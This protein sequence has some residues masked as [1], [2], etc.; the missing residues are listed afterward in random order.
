MTAT[1]SKTYEYQA[2]D[3]KGNRAKGR[4]EALNQ[5][6][7][8]QILRQRGDMPLVVEEAGKGLRRDI[9]VPGFGPKVTLKDLTVLSRQ[10]ATLVSSGM[11]LLRALGVLAEQTSNA[12][13]KEAVTEVRSDVEAGIG[14]SDALGRQSE[15]F[16][17]LMVALVRAGEAGG[18]IDQA[19]EQ[20]AV[21][22]EK[23]SALRSKIKS[24]LTY[25]AI[26][27]AFSVIL[28]AAVLIFIVPIFEDMFAQLGGELPLVT[29]L[30]VSA[31]HAIAWVG[32]VLLALSVGGVLLFQRELK[33]NPAT[34]LA[35]DRFK[36]RLPVFGPLLRKLAM[37]R[38]SRNLGTLLNV[39]VP[40]LNALSVVGATT[41]NA[42][43]TEAMK[44]L[45]DAVREGRPM[46]AQMAEQELFPAMVTQMVEVG[47][48]TGE[49]SQMLGKIADFY[50]REVDT[51]TEQLTSSLEP[52]MVV[53]MGALV[54]GMI[55][56]LYLP[57]FTIYENIQ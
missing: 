39:G 40:M 12:V 4:V 41:G 46:S 55:I 5:A 35:F 14:L 21:T 26:V 23:D 44:G 19:L 15:V 36:L 49:I 32:P 33:R 31:S 16:P 52:I 37:S 38:F 47:E 13:L 1:K 6:A 25:P 18:F 54:G 56:C 8:V 24:A 28:I 50:D 11:S 53:V 2:V 43:V 34:R 10:F 17:M 9:T 30:I 48:E 27:M 51:A 57:M 3:T 7:A 42:V 45:Q 22:F 29:Q 20:V